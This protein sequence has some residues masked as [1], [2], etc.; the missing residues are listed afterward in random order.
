[1]LYKWSKATSMRASCPGGRTLI[2]E[3]GTAPL[4]LTERVWA[5]ASGIVQQLA[6]TQNRVPPQSRRCANVRL[7]C[8]PRVLPLIRSLTEVEESGSNQA[9]FPEMPDKR[10]MS[11]RC[12]GTDVMALVL[13][14]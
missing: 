10:K 8:I 13:W 9:D 3:G 2:D 1:M 11:L 14:Q 12:Y 6:M 4:P 5:G 7:N